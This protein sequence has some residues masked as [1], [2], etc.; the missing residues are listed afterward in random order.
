LGLK[1]LRANGWKFSYEKTVEDV[2]IMYK[3]NANP[4]LAFLLD[5]CEPGEAT[6]Y[7]E[8]TVFYNRFKKYAESHSLRPLSVTKFGELLKD[9][10]EIPVSPFR[11]WVD[12]GDRPRCWQGVKFQSIPSIVAPTPSLAGGK[13]KEKGEEKKKDV[14]KVG[15]K[16]TLDGVDCTMIMGPNPRKYE[17]APTKTV[18]SEG[19]EPMDGLVCY[20]S[21]L[22]AVAIAEYGE[23]GWVNPVKL[24]A[25]VGLPFC[26]VLKGMDHLGY[27]R[28]ERSGGGI[29]YRQKRA[30]SPEKAEA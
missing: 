25:L 20:K 27:E 11:P 13:E 4:V 10:T 24:S 28:Y 30:G 2:E 22:R 26:L 16:P 1:R 15:L 29:A 3:R 23:N 6:D 21:K 19:G 17:P 7:I 5:E 14:D 9:Q 8:K 18:K 12:R